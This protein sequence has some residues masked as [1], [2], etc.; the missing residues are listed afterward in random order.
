[1]LM[2]MRAGA[3]IPCRA[4]V[5]L[6]LPYWLVLAWKAKPASHASRIAPLLLPPPRPRPPPQPR[7]STPS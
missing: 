5:L 4:G 7:P 2:L 6:P 3:I 1:M